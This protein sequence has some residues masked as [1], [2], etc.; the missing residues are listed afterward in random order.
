VRRHGTHA[1][2]CEVERREYATKPKGTGES[3][4]HTPRKHPYSALKVVTIWLT[5]RSKGTVQPSGGL[6]AV[7]SSYFRDHALADAPGFGSAL[8]S[9]AVGARMNRLGLL[10]GS[11]YPGAVT[12]S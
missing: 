5:D 7:H 1:G 4:G 6:L 8:S 12:V 9:K 3:N 11:E 10:R 2:T